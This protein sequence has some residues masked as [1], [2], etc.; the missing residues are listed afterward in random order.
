MTL[1]EMRTPCLCGMEANLDFNASHPLLFKREWKK[2][3]AGSLETKDF[4]FRAGNI[5]S[6]ERKGAEQCQELLD[7]GEMGFTEGAQPQA[8]SA[9]SSPSEGTVARGL[10]LPLHQPVSQRGPRGRQ[11]GVS[12]C[13]SLGAITAISQDSCIP[14]IRGQ[15][16]GCCPVPGAAAELELHKPGSKI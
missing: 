1:M 5:F 7:T 6:S 4:Y 13:S 15:W 14:P 8:P 11:K 3:E 12:A 2:T 9:F 16:Q 10:E